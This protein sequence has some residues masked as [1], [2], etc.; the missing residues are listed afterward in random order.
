MKDRL[1]LVK[2]AS[3]SLSL[4]DNN[5]KNEVL[6]SCSD[7]LLKAVDEILI[8]NEVDLKRA[9]DKH[10]SEGLYDRLLLTEERINNMAIAIQ[11]LIELPDYVGEV[12]EEIERANGLK[13]LKVRV[14]MG[15]IG[16][17]YESRPN[18][19]M[20]A[21]SIAF[22]SG[23]ATVLRGGSDAINTNISIVKVIKKALRENG[24]DEN[25]VLY[26]EDEGHDSIKELITANEYV[27][28][29]IP[30]GGNN[31]IEFVVNN[32]T[33]PAIHTGTGNC[34]VYVDKKADLDMAVSVIEN[35]KTSRLGVCNACESIVVHRAVIESFSKMIYDRL[36]K[37][38]IEIR[39]DEI[40]LGYCD[41][42]I[43]A[44]DADWGMEYLDRIVSLKTV[45]SIEEAIEHINKYGTK[46]SESII[47]EDE[48]AGRLFLNQIDA[49]CVYLNAS[50]RFTDGG[51]FGFGAEIGIST[52]KLHARGPMGLRE[53]TSEKYII[54]GSGQ[55]R[56]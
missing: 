44:N 55:I 14:P 10:I 12:T 16:I 6:K 53:L 19:T 37:Y 33:V 1:G 51:E 46:H 3:Y 8:A 28:L 26:L 23:S 32:A 49:A 56:E 11:N 5:K 15:V 48:E 4:L 2:K 41:G 42:F 25:L 40:G 36:S 29:I 43:P 9:R 24:L 13:I 38:G 31:L 22:K 35:A 52:Q 54:L 7:L 34:H 17:I 30:R 39:A 18:V 45:S 27:D 21:F 50:T 47:T 20:D